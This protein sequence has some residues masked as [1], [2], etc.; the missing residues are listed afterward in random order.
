MP[1]DLAEPLFLPFQATRFV[2]RRKGTD[3]RTHALRTNP[4]LQAQRWEAQRL[5]GTHSFASPARTNETNPISRLDSHPQPPIYIYIYIYIHIYAY[6]YICIYVNCLICLFDLL[7][8]SRNHQY[9]RV[10]TDIYI[11]IYIYTHTYIHTYTYTYIHIY[12]YTYIYVHT[13]MYLYIYMYI[14]I[15]AYICI[16]VYIYTYIYI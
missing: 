10:Y 12:I 1:H 7:K 16:Y 2:D 15:Y 6:I 4:G 13:C 14:E 9:R 3:A 5:T 11:Y 8:G